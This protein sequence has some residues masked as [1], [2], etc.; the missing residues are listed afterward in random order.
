M[1][2]DPIAFSHLLQRMQDT[3]FLPTFLN[4]LLSMILPPSMSRPDFDGVPRALVIDRFWEVILAARNNINL[5]GLCQSQEG[6][7]KEEGKK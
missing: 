6:Q 7:K 2:D 4:M 3:V 5:H 1:K